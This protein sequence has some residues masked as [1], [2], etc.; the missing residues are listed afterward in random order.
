MFNNEFPPLGGGTGTVNFELFNCF[1]NYDNLIIDLISSASGKKKETKKFSENITIHKLP[2]GRKNIHHASNAEL[3]S[4]FIKASFFGIKLGKK[5]KYDFIFV[6]ATVPASFPALI[7]KF[8]KKIPFI[9]RI[10][11]PD[12]PG[13]EQRYNTVYKIISPFIKFAW[14]KSELIISK[15]KSEKEMILEINPKLK[16]KTIYNGVDT[17]KFK[18]GDKNSD[19][20][21][22]LICPARLIKHKGQYTLIKAVSDLKKRGIVVYA[23]LV[24][25]GDEKDALVK[26][27]EEKGVSQEIYFS[28]YV[29]REKMP[30]EYRKADIFVL[31][32]HK[33]GMSNAL[34]EAMACGLPVIVTDVGGTEELVDEKNGFVFKPGDTVALTK[35]LKHI[36]KKKEIINKLGQNSRKKV[37]NFKWKNIAEEY[38]KLF[39]EIKQGK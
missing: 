20:N 31:P 26:F 12:I 8:F 28:E 11:G 17:E 5:N 10:S 7:L 39:D 21:L 9:I 13:Y 19:N 29:P 1:K 32:S 37:E 38:L 30:E 27:A 35:I 25:E 23:N 18:P 16:I 22:R 14:K 24:G 6:W 15:C 4:Y 2:V 34:L 3:I 33:E 36:F